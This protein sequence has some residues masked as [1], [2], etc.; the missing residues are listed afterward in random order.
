MRLLAKTTLNTNATP[1]AIGLSYMTDT[2]KF[3]KYVDTS[4]DYG[5]VCNMTY[6]ATPWLIMGVNKKWKSALDPMNNVK[7]SVGFAGHFEKKL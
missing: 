4:K 7:W 5:I 1:M 2:V 3:D 6:Q